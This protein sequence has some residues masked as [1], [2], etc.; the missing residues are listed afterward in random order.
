MGAWSEDNFGNDAAC[1]WIGDFLE[2]PSLTA[3]QKA[4]N[5]VLN[6][7]GYLE[8]DAACNCLAACEIVARLQGQWGIQNVYTENLDAWV[9]AHPMTIPDDLRAAADAAIEKILG[10]NSELLELWEEE[11]YNSAWHGV[12]DDLRS[13]IQGPAI[14]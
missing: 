3:V 5:K 2:N 10:S 8:S 11:G 1:D 14:A 9:E 7:K 12:V 6:T 13:R 4:I